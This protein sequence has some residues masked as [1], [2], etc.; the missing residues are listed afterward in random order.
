[1][2]SWPSSTTNGQTSCNTKI[3][4]KN[5]NS[6]SLAILRE[7][8]KNHSIE[9]NAEMHSSQLIRLVSDNVL[10][11]LLQLTTWSDVSVRFNLLQQEFTVLKNVSENLPLDEETMQ[12]ERQMI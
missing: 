1:M 11:V 9:W 2:K 7:Q 4:M 10:L 12:M 5:Q 8:T 3:R 6:L